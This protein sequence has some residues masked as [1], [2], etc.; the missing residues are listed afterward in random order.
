MSGR[1]QRDDAASA[2]SRQ[3]AHFDLLVLALKLLILVRVALRRY[4]YIDAIIIQLFANLAD[5]KDKDTGICN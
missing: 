3:N 2:P 1:G 4:I 5:R